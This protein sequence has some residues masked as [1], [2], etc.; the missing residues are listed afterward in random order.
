MLALILIAV[1]VYG[2]DSVCVFV[3]YNAVGI[4]AESANKVF[5][6]FRSVNYFAFIKFIC[7]M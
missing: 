1:T 5:K 4:H 2:D 3:N 7:K 6:L